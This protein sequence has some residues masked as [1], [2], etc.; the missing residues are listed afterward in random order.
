MMNLQ[1]CIAVAI[2]AQKFLAYL[3][4]LCFEKWRPK[5]KYCSSL[6]I[7]HFDPPQSFGLAMPLQT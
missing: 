7:T 4:I 2:G 1:T 5:Q 3:I 6:K